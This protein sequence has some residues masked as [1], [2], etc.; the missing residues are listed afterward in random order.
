MLWRER[1]EW[2]TRHDRIHVAESRPP[3][4]EMPKNVRILPVWEW[5][6]NGE[7]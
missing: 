6:L 5:M 2:P 7:L 4:P 3:F 1:T